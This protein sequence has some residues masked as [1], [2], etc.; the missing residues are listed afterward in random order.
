MQSF[1]R[2]FLHQLRYKGISMLPVFRGTHRLLTF[3]THPSFRYIHKLHHTV[4]L[5]SR[6][7]ITSLRCYRSMIQPS[8]IFLKICFYRNIFQRLS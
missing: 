5:H 8:L 4:P 2:T 3:K 6:L 1:V 7:C